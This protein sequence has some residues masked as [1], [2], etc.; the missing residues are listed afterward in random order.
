MQ[1]GMTSNTPKDQHRHALRETF[2]QFLLFPKR[3]DQTCHRRVND[4]SRDWRWLSRDGVVKEVDHGLVDGM[5][6]LGI[7]SVEADDWPPPIA[8]CASVVWIA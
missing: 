6:T 3:S 4:S 5:P 7:C 1:C 8:L 2:E